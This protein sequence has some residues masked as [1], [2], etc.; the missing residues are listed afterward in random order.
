MAGKFTSH[1]Q[2]HV[3]S[4]N[5]SNRIAGFER[6][7]YVVTDLV[8]QQAHKLFTADEAAL[9]ISK[10]ESALLPLIS[11]GRSAAR[12]HLA[13]L[14]LSGG[15]WE[16]FNQE[17]KGGQLDWRDTLCAAGL[18]HAD[19]PAVLRSRGIDYSYAP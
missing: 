1:F 15:N 5:P 2:S 16:R 12:V 3:W 6:M 14:H 7:S 19:W 4:S 18:E 11:D 9:V 13:I 10:L 8:R 17:L